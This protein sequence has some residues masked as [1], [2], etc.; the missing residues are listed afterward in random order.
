[1]NDSQIGKTVTVIPEEMFIRLGNDDGLIID[2]GRVTIG[3]WIA[4]VT[5]SD[6]EKRLVEMA[7]FNHKALGDKY[8]GLP[9]VYMHYVNKRIT[10]AVVRLFAEEGGSNADI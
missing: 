2:L 6:T 1:M 10:E 3:D 4:M 8:L 7:K 9:L 5:E